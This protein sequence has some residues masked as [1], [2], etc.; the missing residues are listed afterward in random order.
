MK[1]AGKYKNAL[2][3]VAS[4]LRFFPHFQMQYFCRGNGETRSVH[5]RSL[6]RLVVSRD[7][8]FFVFSECRGAATLLGYCFFSHCPS[9]FSLYVFRPSIIFFLLLRFEKVRF[10]AL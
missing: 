5:P 9:L 3:Q 4:D 6:L 8:Y 10:D 2:L 7:G 1:S